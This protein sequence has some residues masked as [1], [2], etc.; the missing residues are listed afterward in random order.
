MVTDYATAPSPPDG[1]SG[2]DPLTGMADAFNAGFAHADRR[3]LPARRRTT[4]S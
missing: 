1:A 3:P 2:S 4:T